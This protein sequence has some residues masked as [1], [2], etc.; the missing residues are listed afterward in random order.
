MGDSS[1]IH[2]E[3][4]LR[5]RAQY[6]SKGAAHSSVEYDLGMPIIKRSRKRIDPR[7]RSE[8]LSLSSLASEKSE[9]SF[10]RKKT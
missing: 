5:S 8:A 2:D 9:A 3:Y 10:L 1:I 6:N 7:R 4:W